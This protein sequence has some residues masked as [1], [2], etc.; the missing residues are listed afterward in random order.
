MRKHVNILLK[1]SC[2]KL[3]VV[4]YVLSIRNQL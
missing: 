1:H 4:S 2:Q 3:R